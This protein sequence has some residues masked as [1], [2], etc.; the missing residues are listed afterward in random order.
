MS[1]RATVQPPKVGL[2]GDYRKAAADYSVPQHWER[3]SE[4]E[5]TLWRA[6]YLRQ[7]QLVLRYACPQYVQALALLDP[8]AGIPNFEATNVQLRRATG[9][10]IVP[11]PG[12]IPDREFFEHLAQRR[13]PVTVWLRKPEEFDY[14]AEPD[15]FHDYFGHVPLLFDPTYADHMQAYGVGGLKALKLGA[16]NYLAR[17]Y[18]YT[19]EFG[20]IRTPKGLRAYGAG[21]LSS[22]GE[23][24]YC[25]DNETPRR[26]AFTPMRAMQT[27][28]RIDTYQDLYFVVEDFEHLLRD[29]APDFTPYYN[30]LRSLPTLSPTQTMRNDRRVG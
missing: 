14:I 8:S 3:Y 4:A 25:I 23:L 7:S 16:L 22:A 27:D 12:L 17:L 1:A 21:L 10:E 30:R 2:R 13:F 15:V 11:V 6:L 5:H 9:W 20:L 28:Y 26:I 18:W 29:T 24:P 19:I